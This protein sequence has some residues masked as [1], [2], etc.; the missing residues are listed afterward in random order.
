MNTDRIRISS[1]REYAFIYEETVDRI[2]TLLEQATLRPVYHRPIELERT[3]DR[4]PVYEHEFY[5][6]YKGRDI[7]LNLDRSTCKSGVGVLEECTLYTSTHGVLRVMSKFSLDVYDDNTLE[8]WI[9]L[10]QSAIRS[11]ETHH[12]VRSQ[13]G[14]W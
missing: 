10:V 7:T 3:D 13:A 9:T 12:V 8:G 5:F 2:C 4:L 1:S 11:L 14:V 6:N